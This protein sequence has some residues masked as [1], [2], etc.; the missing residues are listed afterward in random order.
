MFR[1]KLRGT[2]VLHELTR[3]AALDFFVTFSSVTAQIGS[4][5]LAAYAAANEFVDALAH[6]RRGLGLP[7]LTVD[8][9]TWEGTALPID[10][11]EREYRRYGFRE[12]PFERAFEALE[13]LLLSGAVQRTVADVDWNVLKPVYQMR[14]ERSMLRRIELSGPAAGGRMAHTLRAAPRDARWKLLLDFLVG[15]VRAVL[16]HEAGG[17]LDVHAGFFEMGMDSLMGLK[18]KKRVE[19]ELAVALPSTLI[20]SSPTLHALASEL[21][22]R[23]LGIDA[24]APAPR[25]APIAP[26]PSRQ[27]PVEEEV[28]ALADHDLA[29]VLDRELSRSGY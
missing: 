9:G 12:M 8:W 19:S 2:W 13:Q 26:A 23:H 14:R 17:P 24:P 27:R 3:D 6:W 29:L 21:A 28:G 18:L 15:E 1:A 16:G 20:F 11:R 7:S 5:G 10:G 22:A 4:Y 25:A